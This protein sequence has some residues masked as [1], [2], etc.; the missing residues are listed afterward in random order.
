MNDAHGTQ[1]AQMAPEPYRLIVGMSNDDHDWAVA[2]MTAAGSG[3][4]PGKGGDTGRP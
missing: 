3:K 1:S 2:E 4:H